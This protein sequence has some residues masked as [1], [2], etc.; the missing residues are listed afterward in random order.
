MSS[1]V[2][3]TLA[4]SLSLRG[5]SDATWDLPRPISLAVNG[6]DEQVRTLRYL[7]DPAPVAQQ[8]LM[9]GDKPVR[10]FTWDDLPLTTTIHVTEQLVATVT[11][12]LSPFRSAATYPLGPITPDARPYLAQ[13]ADLALPPA[14]RSLT[15]RLVRRA[16]TEAAAVN[17][18]A[19]WVATHTHYN[20]AFLNG[21]A[22]AA[23]VFSGHQA[24]CT[25]YANLMAGMLR[26]LDI[27]A[28][29]V[30]G[31]ALS[32]RLRFPISHGLRTTLQWTAPG[33]AGSPHV[34]LEV[35]FPDAGWVPFDPQM[36]K[37]FVD[38]RHVALLRNVDAGNLAPQLTAQADPA[39]DAS[40]DTTLLQMTVPGL[41]L[42]SA[43]AA[44]TEDRFALRVRGM[45]HDQRRSVLFSR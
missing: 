21:P 29:A 39:G 25:G 17:D 40:G 28:R 22:D 43:T 11:D 6:Y 19:N 23:S 42:D 41:A 38:T 8:N 26:V 4:G 36:E 27:P 33:T 20:T 12:R 1:Q 31:W 45:L 14:A 24:V 2:R 15:Q 16:A 34:W 7:F 37:F 18:V 3:L 44:T 32:S 9:L 5:A 10:R 13:T 30:F 35:W